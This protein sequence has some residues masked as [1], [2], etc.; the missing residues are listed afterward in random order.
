MAKPIYIV[1]DSRNV[2]LC[3]A[4][5]PSVAFGEVADMLYPNK[6]EKEIKKAKLA[7][8]F[9]DG[10]MRHIGAKEFGSI[11]SAT[12]RH[13]RVKLWSTEEASELSEARA[14]LAKAE[15]AVAL[16]GLPPEIAELSIS[17]IRE[18]IEE[19][20][21]TD[22]DSD[23]HHYFIEAIVPTTRAYRS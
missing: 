9:S 20:E 1:T 16:L 19:L 17:P 14:K 4:N 21:N 15:A 8:E 11:V 7:A 10:T 13:A 5:A 12:K 23:V 3:V 18:R 22:E 6:S 2:N